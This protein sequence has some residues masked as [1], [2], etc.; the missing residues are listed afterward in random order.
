VNKE[1]SIRRGSNI[2]RGYGPLDVFLAEQRYKTARKLLKAAKKNRRIL[3]IGCGAYPFFLTTVD[4]AE[5]FGFDKIAPDTP[6]EKTKIEGITL[7]SSKDADEQ[8]LPFENGYF[9]AVT[10]LAVFEH[11]EPVRLVGVHR[12]IRRALKPEG[13][14]I[15]TTPAFWTDPL[16]RILARLGIISNVEIKEHKGSYGKKAIYRVLREAGFEA[17]KLQYGYFEMFMNSWTTATK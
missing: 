11:I 9:D 7:I 12:E 1:T 4:F 15:M 6:D 16:L 3:D 17:D 5:K 10:M 13:L 8:S 14:Y 2:V